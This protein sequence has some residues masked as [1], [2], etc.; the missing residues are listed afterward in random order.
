MLTATIL[1]DIEKALKTKEYLII[2]E[3]KKRLPPELYDIV[4]LFNKQEAE[5]LTPYREG[6]N[7]RI[8]LRAKADSSLPALP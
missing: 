8:E 1:A 3:L 2:E 4:L 6:I 7:H 5:K